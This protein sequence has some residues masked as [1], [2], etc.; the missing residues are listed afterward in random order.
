MLTV[1]D[2]YMVYTNI[3]RSD[4]GKLQFIQ[5]FYQELHEM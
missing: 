2:I 4:L 3:G 5:E 1:M